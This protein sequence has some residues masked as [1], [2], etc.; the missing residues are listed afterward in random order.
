MS[1]GSAFSKKRVE[2]LGIANLTSP[3]NFMLRINS[4]IKQAEFESNLHE[5][6][7]SGL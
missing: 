2:F 3:P 5:Q 1:F 6:A 4:F 7:S